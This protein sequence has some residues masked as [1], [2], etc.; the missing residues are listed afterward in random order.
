MS[1]YCI[2]VMFQIAGTGVGVHVGWMGR[3]AAVGTSV[4]AIM[5]V[6]GHY[7]IIT[8]SVCT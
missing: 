6:A 8:V 5:A 2:W 4:P 1:E 3:R 7:H